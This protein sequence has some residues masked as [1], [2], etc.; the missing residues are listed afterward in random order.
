[1]TEQIKTV[2]AFRL[3]EEEQ[4]LSSEDVVRNFKQ[5]M[6]DRR[7]GMRTKLKNSDSLSDP[8]IKVQDRRRI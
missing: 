7:S 4:A 3:Y 1:M 6:L 8:H 2:N 5:Q